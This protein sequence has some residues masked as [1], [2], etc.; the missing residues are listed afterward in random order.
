MTI[1]GPCVEIPPNSLKLMFTP[2]PAKPASLILEMYS[3]GLFEN[4]PSRGCILVFTAYPEESNSKVP[5]ESLKMTI[6]GPCVEIPPRS[7]K[8]IFNSEPAKPANLRL[9]MNSLGH[10]SNPPS[11]GF[12]L[13]FTPCPE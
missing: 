6:F 2:D 13:I 5:H 8:L 11:R 3:F 7:L 1:F 12:I 9:E 4:P 10:F